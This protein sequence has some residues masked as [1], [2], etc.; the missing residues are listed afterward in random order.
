MSFNK[1]SATALQKIAT[2]LL[3]LDVEAKNKLIA[4]ND[5]VIHI[6]VTDLTL[7]YYF[8]FVD[9]QILIDNQLNEELAG[10]NE[11]TL[12]THSSTAS[13]SAVSASTVSASISGNLSAFIAA[14]AA[15]H[16]ADSVF[17]GEL[18]FSGE[19]NTAKRFQEFAQSLN[20]DWQEPLAQ[21]FGDPIGHTI[22]TGLQKLS[23]WVLNTANSVTQDISEYIQ[24]EARVTPSYIEQQHFFQQVDQLRSQVDRLNARANQLL[25]NQTDSDLSI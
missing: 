21:T 17:K 19:I 24:E 2:R 18:H 3:R 16:S 6:Q 14:A 9:G 11:D 23:G 4:F 7:D 13:L 10:K 1:L 5:K 12:A 25:A 22:A 15:E 20:I 8:S